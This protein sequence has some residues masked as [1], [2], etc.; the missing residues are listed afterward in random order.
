MANSYLEAF[1][2]TSCNL[3]LETSVVMPFVC[4]QDKPTKFCESYIQ[5]VYKMTPQDTLSQSDRLIC[6]S[7]YIV[8]YKGNRLFINNQSQYSLETSLIDLYLYY[9]TLYLLLPDRLFTLNIKSIKVESDLVLTQQFTSMKV[10]NF[11]SAVYLFNPFTIMKVED[12]SKTIVREF[13]SKLESFDNIIDSDNLICVVDENGLLEV[14]DFEEEEPICSH[15][16]QCPVTEVFSI[17]DSTILYYSNTRFLIAGY[18]FKEK[19]LKYTVFF[20]SK[21]PKQF[22]YCEETEQMLI[23]NRNSS[24]FMILSF[25]ESSFISKYLVL[26]LKTPARAFEHYI[27]ENTL[28]NQSIYE[29][30]S[31]HKIFTFNANNIEVYI[32]EVLSTNTLHYRFGK[33]PQALCINEDLSQGY[34]EYSIIEKNE[35]FGKLK[36]EGIK[37]PFI[38]GKTDKPIKDFS[39]KP[40]IPKCL[41]VNTKREDF[42]K[43]TPAPEAHKIQKISEENKINPVTIEKNY[44]LSPETEKIIQNISDKMSYLTSGDNFANLL[45]SVTENIQPA[46]RKNIENST[47][48]TLNQIL[49]GPLKDTTMKYFEPL[50]NSLFIG[51]Q[52]MRNLQNEL[53]VL[54]NTVVGEIKEVNKGQKVMKTEFSIE[55]I[56]DIVNKNDKLQLKKRFNE[57]NIVEILNRNKDERFVF[58]LGYMIVELIREVPGLNSYAQMLK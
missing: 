27:I 53:N 19:Q 48:N 30:N 34:T 29:G 58:G 55:S 54:L 2:I 7:S 43:R 37:N 39:T 47:Q 18:N 44:E 25:D 13:Q 35:S 6:T 32:L 17:S 26:G 4:D 28:R 11:G 46:L 1:G 12:L 24:K 51:L 31:K 50:Q 5:R 16:C 49:S 14:L 23:L 33:E 21:C 8:Q 9:D 57:F 41:T 22:H 56:E 45:M 3:G 15:E 42:S 20:N 38:L 10:K 36:N 40:L 52:E